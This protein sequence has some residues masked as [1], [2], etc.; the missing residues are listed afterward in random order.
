[1]KRVIKAATGNETFWRVYYGAPFARKT[2]KFKDKN[3]LVRWLRSNIFLNDVDGVKIE[4][5]KDW[6]PGDL[7]TYMNHYEVKDKA[8][9]RKLFESGIISWNDYNESL[10]SDSEQ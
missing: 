5:V 2:K 6:D 4:E 3:D 8:L 1:M 9:S 10:H 7:V